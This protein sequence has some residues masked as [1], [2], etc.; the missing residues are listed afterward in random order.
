[1]SEQFNIEISG[2]TIPLK[3]IH[4]DSEGVVHIPHLWID[5][6]VVCEE[7]PWPHRIWYNFKI[8]LTKTMLGQHIMIGVRVSVPRDGIAVEI[9][10][11]KRSFVADNCHFDGGRLSSVRP[12]ID[13]IQQEDG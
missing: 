7:P 4:K 3:K 11:D 12:N 5:N 10:A 9:N 8:W 1:M 13:R 2:V 6:G